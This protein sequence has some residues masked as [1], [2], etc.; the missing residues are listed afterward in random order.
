MSNIRPFMA[1]A[2]DFRR[3]CLNDLTDFSL[4]RSSIASD[5]DRTL[6]WTLLDPALGGLTLLNSLKIGRKH[7]SV[8]L[9]ETLRE[10]TFNN[11]KSHFA[12]VWKL[13]KINLT[14]FSQKFRESNVF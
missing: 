9:N 14:L 7:F 13:R 3:P 1:S 2:D 10:T 6:N 11:T 12:T 8:L 4:L 5:F